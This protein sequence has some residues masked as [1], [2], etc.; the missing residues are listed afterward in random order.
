MSTSSARDRGARISG[1]DAL[2]PT[3]VPAHATRTDSGRPSSSIRFRT[4]TPMATSVAWRRSVRDRSSV[5]DHPLVAGDRR[6]AGR[7]DLPELVVGD[8]AG[9]GDADLG[10]GARHGRTRPERMPGTYSGSE[11]LNSYLSDGSPSRVRR[12]PVPDGPGRTLSR[13]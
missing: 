13:V 9:G 10:E 12:R 4:R 1:A 6:E 3:P 11:R 7:R 5:S 8:L 2:T